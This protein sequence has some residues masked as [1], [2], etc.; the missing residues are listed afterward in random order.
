MTLFLRE[1]LHSFLGHLNDT[2]M[3]F[4]LKETTKYLTVMKW[5]PESSDVLY[6]HIFSMTMSQSGE[7]NQCCI[8]KKQYLEML[9]DTNIHT[10]SV[11]HEPPI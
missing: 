6:W 5:R 1:F 7:F 10:Y 8:K 11:K 3:T 9:T 2:P 4:I